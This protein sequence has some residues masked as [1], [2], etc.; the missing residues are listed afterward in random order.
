MTKI[1]LINPTQVSKDVPVASDIP[2]LGLCYLSSVLKESGYKNI[3]GIDLQKDSENN[4]IKDFKTA[5]IAGIHVTSKLKSDAERLCKKLRRLNKNLLIVVGGPHAT[6]APKEI[7]SQDAVDIVVQG[8]GEYAFLEI[9]QAIENDTSLADVKGIWF[10]DKGNVRFSQPRHWLKNLDQL[11]FPDRDIFDANRYK[12]YL[13]YPP[14]IS[15]MATRSCPFNCTNCQPALKQIA[16]P[17]RMRSSKNIVSEIKDVIKRYGYRNF[18]FNDNDLVISKVWTMKLCQEMIK[19]K[20]RIQWGCAARISS[21]DRE[22]LKMMK[23]AGCITIH[24]GVEFGVQRVIDEVLK[25][26]ISIQRAKKVL[27]NATKIGLRTNCFYMCGIPGSTKE[28]E[29]ESIRVAKTLKTNSISM[30]VTQPQENIEMTRTCKEKGWLLPH[31]T[32]D[33]DG[34]ESFFRTPEWGPEFIRK[35]TKWIIKEFDKE[36]WTADETLVFRNIKVDVRKNFII[37]VGREFL[38]FL[39]DFKLNRI[40]WIFRGIK[41]KIKYLL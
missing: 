25:K 40:K 5:D 31:S 35:F 13:L 37:F 11:A 39:K 19:E 32:R 41:Y 7:I 2:P 18:W 22:L 23:K 33:L 9:V 28:E 16:G 36:G 20:L 6:I 34:K 29:Y 4:F 17:Y 14:F 12:T 1:L 3:L 10:K 30:Q 24:F 38:T 27:E 26:G 21:V 15:L 8:E